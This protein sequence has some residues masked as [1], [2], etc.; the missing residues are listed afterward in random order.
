MN[1]FLHRSL[2]LAFAPALALAFAFS[3][4]AP[5]AFASDDSGSA[6]SSER[7]EFFERKIRPVLVDHCYQCHSTAAKKSKGGLR[8]DT[9][10]GLLKGG[11]SGSAVT[12]GDPD[13]SLLL[14]AI[15]YQD[16]PRMP[17]DGKLP[18]SVIADFETWIKQGAHDPR[19]NAPSVDP[20]SNPVP[21]AEAES[22]ANDPKSTIDWAAAKTHWSFQTPKRHQA[23]EV[24]DV[25]WSRQPIDSF[26]LAKIEG[27][28]LKPAPAADR[29]AWLR[30]VT[31]DTIGLPPTPEE[32]DA[33]LADSSPSAEVKVVDRLLASPHF[34]E[35]WARLWLDVARYAEDQAHIVG[36][37]D[38]LFYPNAYLYRDWVINALNADMPFD[39]FVKL[40]LAA[41][42][43]EPNDPSQSPALGFL[44]LGPKYYSRKSAAVMADEWEDRVDVVSRGLMGLTVACARCHDHKYDPIT[45]DDYYALAGVFASTAMFNKPLDD[46]REL[47]KGGVDAKLPKDSMHMVREDKPTDLNIAIRGDVESKGAVAKRH[48]PRVLCDAEPTPFSQGSG[49]KELADRIADKSNPLTSRVIVN[50]IWGQMFG[51]PLVASA[52]NF[53]KLGDAPTHPELLDDLAS[54][55]VEGGWS[56]KGLIREFAL[57]AAYRQDSR[58]D[59]QTLAADPDNRLVSRMSRRRMSA[60]AWRD[61][62]L[63]ATGRLD[64]AIGGSSI[65][66]LDFEARRRTIYSQASRLSLNPYLAL[67]D[68]PDANIHSDRRNL[69]TT[70]PQK[71]F[72]L[73]SPFMVRQAEALAERL[74]RDIPAQGDDFQARR[75]DSAYRLLFARPAT[76][77]DQRIAVEFIKSSRDSEAGWKTYLHA[78]LASNEALF[79][80]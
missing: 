2:R 59:A 23:P 50:R 53:G 49:R 19:E 62:M 3:C 30:R 38:S 51:R 47:G 41:D 32:T 80:D 43:I 71:L 6:A 29:R 44:G 9:R 77:E 31:F 72:A 34:G 60:E 35:R 58:C 11:D 33:F 66:P 52:S 20:S 68:Y 26:L 70:P 69:T 73:N 79:L 24:R 46:K 40:Q 17:P 65:D 78:L 28:G 61:A 48:F 54:R 25:S 45:T 76:D 74:S 7:R 42:V 5:R 14:D 27:A 22:S 16:E 55:F 4:F 15:R 12:P 18:D 57:S 36:K 37:D 63:A 75:V 39:R 56:L 1:V 13:E 21:A 67:F 10:E 8:L 64:Q